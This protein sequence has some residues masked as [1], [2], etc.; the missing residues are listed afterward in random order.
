MKQSRGFTT[1][2]VITVLLFAIIAASLFYTQQ[3]ALQAA[4]RDNTRKTAIN[5]IYY[6]LE[7]VFYRQVNYY[8]Q[9]I[10]SSDLPAMD[11]ELLT[12]PDGYK[13]GDKFSNYQYT[14]KDCDLDGKCQG[15]RLTADMEREAEYVKTSRH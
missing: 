5:A 13:L 15:Y 4:S 10:D 1:I 6:N 8:P 2:E 12:D 14:A 3:A 7:E 11:P 9:T